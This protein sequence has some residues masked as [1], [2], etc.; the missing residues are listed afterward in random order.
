[1]WREF[2][3]FINRGNVMDLAVGVIIGAAFGKIVSS[4]VDDLISPVLGKITGGIDLS[5]MA[6]SLGTKHDGDKMVE[7]AIK[8]GSFIQNIINFLIVAFVIF[9]LVKAYNRLRK[10]TPKEEPKPVPTPTE[11]LL[12]EIRDLLKVRA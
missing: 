7:V 11:S 5:K 12:A 3:E 6:V 8:Y 9:L 1:M 4:V 10:V 2:K